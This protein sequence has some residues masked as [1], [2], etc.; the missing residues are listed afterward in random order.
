VGGKMLINGIRTL[1]FILFLIEFQ[2]ISQVGNILAFCPLQDMT[3]VVPSE[4]F[5]KIQDAID[6]AWENCIIYIKS[7][8]Y[9]ENIRIF[10]RKSIKVI[11]EGN[12]TVIMGGEGQNVI[13]VH[14]SSNIT[15]MNFLVNASNMNRWGIYIILSCNINLINVTVMN[16]YRGVYFWDASRCFLRNNR[17]A[18]NLYNFEV[19]GLTP[20]HFY[21]DIDTSNTVNGQ[22]IYYLVNKNN[23]LVPSN[24]GYVAVIN[25]SGVLVPNLNLT[26][27]G[28]GVLLAYATN[29]KL[30]NIYVSN[31]VRGVHMVVC[32]NVTIASS[33]IEKCDEGILLISSRNNRVFKNN[34][35]KGKYGIELSYSIFLSERCECNDICQNNI[36][37]NEVGLLLFGSKH[38]NFTNNNLMKN[39]FGVY[40]YN[41]SDN[42]FFC[43]NFIE[44]A[45][46]V[47]VFDDLSSN[48]WNRDYPF[49]GNNWSGYSGPDVY[50]G[51]SQN[52]IGGDLIGDEPYIINPRNVDKYPL[53][54]LSIDFVYQPLTPKVMETVNF[55]GIVRTPLYDVI[56]WHWEISDGSFYYG[57]S[58]LHKFSQVGCFNVT[59]IVCDSRG[60]IS[61]FTK[62]VVVSSFKG[63]ERGSSIDVFRVFALALLLACF[64]V[65]WFLIYRR[66][67]LRKQKLKC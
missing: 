65:L 37:D 47:K 61:V 36:K 42:I 62:G 24:A 2:A 29:T 41:S 1:M 7:G 58:V 26:N 15:L 28:Q 59:L 17:L 53:I 48:I 5:Q 67:N 43:N 63:E 60:V 11:G 38:N 32:S 34:I 21:H 20:L 12:S 23:F 33:N 27:N 66:R 49:G 8:V 13:E 30:E 50:C 9:F 31:N 46:H 45:V 51:S 16:G 52:E 6:K 22:P 57:R 18:R 10:Q 39:K 44:N 14:Y 25:S 64:F 54:P 35:I 55:T 4:R 40:I 19:W 3:F 56:S